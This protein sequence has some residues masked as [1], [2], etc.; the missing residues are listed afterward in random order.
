MTDNAE[1]F[2][3]NGLLYLEKLDKHQNY[4]V[5]AMLREFDWGIK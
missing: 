4:L 5:R 2:Y 3:N 1:Q